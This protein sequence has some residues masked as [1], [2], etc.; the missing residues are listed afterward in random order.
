V[1]VR[2]NEEVEEDSEDR[3]T[4]PRIPAPETSVGAKPRGRA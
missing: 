3:I 1:A 4:T 2:S